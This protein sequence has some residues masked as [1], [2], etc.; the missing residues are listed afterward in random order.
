MKVKLR[1]TMAGPEGSYQAGTIINLPDEKAEALINGGYANTPK[2]SRSH[3]TRAKIG[4]NKPPEPSAWIESIEYRIELSDARIATL[5]KYI[6]EVYIER[7]RSTMA[8]FLH[9][10]AISN[11]NSTPAEAFAAIIQFKSRIDAYLS[12]EEP[13]EDQ[14]ENLLEMLEH[15]R[16]LDGRSTSLLRHSLLGLNSQADFDS[17]RRYLREWLGRQKVRLV[18][19]NHLR[20]EY[21]TDQKYWPNPI[22]SWTLPDGV[23]PKIKSYL[24]LI[25][26]SCTSCVD[27][28]HRNGGGQKGRRKNS[29]KQQLIT[30]LI[31]IFESTPGNPPASSAIKSKF[32]KFVTQIFN[33]LRDKEE[34]NGLEPESL[35]SL[36]KRVL[37]KKRTVS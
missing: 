31:V 10:H 34:L 11:T 36:V 15:N 20:E 1:T 35:R 37:I 7:L 26:Q 3:K 5:K 13:T 30:E 21:G 25:A 9:S 24:C 23:Y 16:G 6:S 33:W 28:N 8:D 19:K 27:K 22:Q 4:D 2:T 17:M 29:S 14:I 12:K 18:F 32:M